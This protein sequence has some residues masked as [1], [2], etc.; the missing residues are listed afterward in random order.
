M[1]HASPALLVNIFGGVT[2]KAGDGLDLM[3]RQEFRQ[4]VH[5]RLEQHGKIAPI[6]HVA[7]LPARLSD[8]PAEVRIQFW[9]SSGNV[10]HFDCRALAEQFHGSP[11]YLAGHDFRPLGSGVHM[12][13]MAGLVA[14]LAHVDLQCARFFAKERPTAMRR[15][16]PLEVGRGRVLGKD[17]QRI[18][19]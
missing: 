10:N 15:E 17:G 6:N 8:Q 13:V 19:R 16:S 3:L 5:S 18:V 4:L 9:R 11:S 12:A 7:P 2:G 14:Q 1:K